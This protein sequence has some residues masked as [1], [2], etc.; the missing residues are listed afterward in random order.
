MCVYCVVLQTLGSKNLS[1][2]SRE[3]EHGQKD[4]GSILHAPDLLD[5]PNS[6]SKG[7]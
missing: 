1:S 2:A 4:R 5:G 6:Q 3:A 7:K